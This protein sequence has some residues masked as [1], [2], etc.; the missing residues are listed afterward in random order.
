MFACSVSNLLLSQLDALLPS[1]PPG[2]PRRRMGMDQRPISIPL[3]K[4]QFSVG[5]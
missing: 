3:K 4:L 2:Q 5:L 1:G